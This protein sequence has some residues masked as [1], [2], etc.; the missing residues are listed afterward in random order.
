MSVRALG[1][2]ALLIS[3]CALTITPSSAALPSPPDSPQSPESVPSSNVQELPALSAPLPAVSDQ[4]PGSARAQKPDTT[5]EPEQTK[6]PSKEVNAEKPEKPAEA[7]PPE[8]PAR[9]P[10]YSV[11]EQGTVVTEIHD[12]FPSPYIGPRSLLPVEP[13]A[14]SETATLF[15][16]ARLWHGADIVFNPEIAGGT[17]FSGTTGIAGFPNGEITRV[18]VVAPTP[19]IARLFFRQT[20]GRITLYVGKLS[21]TDLFDL[22]RYSHDPR[23][24]FGN[25]ALMYNGAWDYPANVRGY[26]Y[27]V[28][29]EFTETY[30][31]LRYGIF[32]EPAIANGAEIDPHIA[33]ANGQILELEERYWLDDNPGRVREWVFLNH[34]HMGDYLESLEAMPVTPDVTLTRSYR[35]KYGFGGNLEQQITPELG[36]FL[37]AGWNDGR[38]ESWAFTA[39]DRTVALGLTLAGKWWKRPQDQVGLAG[40]VNGLAKDHRDYLRAGGLDFIIGDGRLNYAPE[41]IIEAYY[42]WQLVKGILV[43]ADFQGVNHPAYNADRGPVAIAGLR[44]HFEH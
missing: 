19:Y 18:G 22:N 26:D 40:V 16:D 2:W 35:Y 31:A 28:A 38:T 11:H 27:G 29:L 41:Q 44:V 10:W 25:W 5:G 39:I 36:M 34:A 21:M 23:T 30:W 32:A 33:R 37:K 15:L 13:A 9:E 24:Q 12:H 14:T 6:N 8:R 43:T 4:K 7:P 42:N 1:K 3:L 17:G 20:W